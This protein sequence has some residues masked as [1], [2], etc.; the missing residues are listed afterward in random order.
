MTAFENESFG[1]ALSGSTRTAAGASLRACSGRHPANHGYDSPIRRIWDEFDPGLGVGYA[2][3]VERRLSGAL[4]VGSA[5]CLWGTWSLFFRP[6]EAYGGVT[7]ALETFVVFGVVFLI[8]IP[9]ALVERPG[10]PRPRGAWALLGLSGVLD[11]LNALFFFWAMQTTTL[12]VAVLTHYLAPIL[13]AS[14][15]PWLAGERVTRRTFGAIA[16]ALS[17]LCVLL[18]PWRGGT[19]GVG[20]G[21]AFGVLSAVFFASSLLTLKRVGRHFGPAEVLAWHMPT[22]L[23]TLAF[24]LPSHPFAISSSALAWLVIGGLGPGALAGVLFFRGLARLEASRASVLMLL[25]PLTAVLVGVVVWKELFGPLSAI[26]AGLVLFA[27]YRV[28]SSERTHA[29]AA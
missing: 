9:F 17:G 5:A 10:L 8:S 16:I 1:P 27:A 6:A 22:A 12:A 3:T 25:E 4:M 13:V 7:P 21:A 18:E 11:A 19:E 2:P 29:G 26:G 20:R 23:I 15:A 28:L 24:F 14:L